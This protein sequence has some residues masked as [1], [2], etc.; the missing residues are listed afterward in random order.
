MMLSGLAPHVS[1]LKYLLNENS[2]TIL[3]VAGVGGT[4][5]TA[6]LTGRATFKAAELIKEEELKLDPEAYW[7]K[8]QAARTRLTERYPKI[9]DAP[10][11]VQKEFERLSEVSLSKTEKTKLVWRHYLPPVASG[12][13]TI[14][15]IIL[16]N[17]ISSKKIAALTIAGGISERAFQEYKDKVVEKLGPRQDEKVRDELAQDRVNA[18]PVSSREVMIVGTGDVLFFDELTGRYF[19][20]TMEDVKRAENK[21]NY[22]LINFMSC[23]LSHFYEEI[24]LPPTPYTDSV[25][26]NMNNHMEVKFSTTLSDD[27]RPCIVISF[28]R[29]PIPD[30]QKN[31]D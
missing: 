28:A 7:P 31:W 6:Y 29:H 13:L 10:K 2:T 20:S 16:A 30:Y 3:T 1:K 22:E 18:N 8:A 9:E 17:K 4:I 12:I 24:G 14:T 27:N 21:V 26:W 25:G 23:S 11:E 19:Q 5:A 15:F